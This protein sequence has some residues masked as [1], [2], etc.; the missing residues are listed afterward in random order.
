MKHRAGWGHGLK[1]AHELFLLHESFSS[2]ISR[3]KR[4]PF[5]GPTAMTSSWDQLFSS[6]FP[7]MALWRCRHC[8]SPAENCGWKPWMA[9]SRWALPPVYLWNIYFMLA[10]IWPQHVL[11]LTLLREIIVPW[12]NDLS[13]A[14]SPGGDQEVSFYSKENAAWFKDQERLWR[15]TYP[16]PHSR[17]NF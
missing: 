13:L 1:F 6:N 17:P 3:C 7:G 12:P 4:G 10:L 9:R 14:P 16:Q 11:M 2:W 15:K 5:R 8:R